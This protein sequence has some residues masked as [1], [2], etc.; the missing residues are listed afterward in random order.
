MGIYWGVS[1]SAGDRKDLGRTAETDDRKMSILSVLLDHVY[2]SILSLVVG[3]F[4]MYCLGSSIGLGFSMGR[5]MTAY[6]HAG[7]FC[8]PLPNGQE[9][10]NPRSI[11]NLTSVLSVSDLQVAEEAI[12]SYSKGASLALHFEGTWTWQMAKSYWINHGQ[13]VP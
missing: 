6:F 13:Q 10:N 4:L 5:D 2:F 7:F 3:F 8:F 11:I 9:H 1:A 12:F